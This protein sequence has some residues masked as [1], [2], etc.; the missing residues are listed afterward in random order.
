MLSA[1]TPF[2]SVS[3]H[4]RLSFFLIVQPFIWVYFPGTSVYQLVRHDSSGSFQLLWLM[5]K[6]IVW[7]LSFF[8]N[9]SAWDSSN[10]KKFS[11]TGLA[12]LTDKLHY[13]KEIIIKNNYKFNPECFQNV[14]QSRVDKASIQEKARVLASIC[15]VVSI[16]LM[17]L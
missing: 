9:P 6:R 16:P 5:A 3:T 7:L 15:F 2:S 8:F 14:Q 10:G 4:D 1:L 11:Q 17:T 13:C 12:Q